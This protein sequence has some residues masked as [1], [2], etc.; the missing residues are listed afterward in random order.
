[1]QELGW[2]VGLVQRGGSGG[3]ER[4]FLSF[5][6]PNRLVMVSPLVSYEGDYQKLAEII[7]ELCLA[8]GHEQ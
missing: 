1:M 8:Y 7:H 6:M 4:L 2:N 3:E 5:L